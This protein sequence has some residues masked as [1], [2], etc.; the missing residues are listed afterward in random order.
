M[1]DEVAVQ[2]APTAGDAPVAETPAP[3][4]SGLEAAAAATQADEFTPEYVHKLREE[5]A[6]YRTK[7]S[8]FTDTFDGYEDAE[9]EAFLDLARTLK[10]DPQTAAEWFEQ[11]AQ[12]IKGGQAPAAPAQQ[13]AAPAADDRPLTRAELD[14]YIAERDRARSEQEAQ[15]N[16]IKEIH[17]EI[18]ELGVDPDSLDGLAVMKVAYEQTGGDI[19]AAYKIAVE[20]RRNSWIEQ[21]LAEKEKDGGVAGSVPDGVGGIPSTERKIKSLDDAVAAMKDRLS[22][23]SL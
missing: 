9:I 5:A 3:E 2:E 13:Q 18:K 8:K 21:Y 23:T 10:T 22:R 6:D 1:P 17:S 12:N 20:D 11:V 4:G 7:A 19:K 14:A 16:A 15:Q